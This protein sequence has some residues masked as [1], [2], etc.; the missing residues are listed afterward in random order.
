MKKLLLAAASL[1]VMGGIASAADLTKANMDMAPAMSPAPIVNWEGVYFGGHLGAGW[2]IGNMTAYTP[3][4]SYVG[5]SVGSLDAGSVLGG[6]QLG[7]N[8]QMGNGLVLGIEA[9]VSAMD[10]SRH[11]TNNDPGTDF[12]RS[13]NWTGTLAGKMGFTVDRTMLYGKAGLAVGGFEVG[14]N[15]NGTLISNSSTEYGYVLGAGIEYALDTK[16]SANIE[17][18]FMDFGDD[19][20]NISGP[21]ADIRIAPNGDAHILKA[22]LNYRF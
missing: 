18:N 9:A 12:W 17:Y 5:F 11:S 21:S 13:L 10:I 14:H 16:W 22:G 20:V 3:Y 6:V 15:Q 1:V 19:Q 7:Y 8:H 2:L 4:N